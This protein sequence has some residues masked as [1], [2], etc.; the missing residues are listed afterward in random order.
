MVERALVALFAFENA[1]MTIESLL[2]ERVKLAGQ[3]IERV[4][5][6]AAQCSSSEWWE[7][8]IRD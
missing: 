2:L 4:A 3:V 7:K 1:E 5:A 8:G 6:H